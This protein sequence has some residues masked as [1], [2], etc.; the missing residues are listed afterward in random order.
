MPPELN[1]TA[2]LKIVADFGLI[3]LVIFLWWYDNRN[4]ERILAQYKR[5]MDELRKMYENNV[6]LCR[7]FAEVA[8]DLRDVLTLNIQRL[9][10][11]ADAVR[12]NQFCPLVRV[13]K[14][15][16]VRLQQIMQENG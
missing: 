6:S 7:D 15:K 4:I 9:T 13:D 11:L 16:V 10:E 12:Q 5:D 3:G 8:R 2:L 1:V 14:Q